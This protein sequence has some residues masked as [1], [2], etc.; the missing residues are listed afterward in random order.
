MVFIESTLKTT[1]IS[2]A[3]LRI[4]QP[5][6]SISIRFLWMSP[7][8]CAYSAPGNF[9]SR[10]LHSLKCEQHSHWDSTHKGGADM[11]E[12]I[13]IFAIHLHLRQQDFLFV[14][15]TKRKKKSPSEN[16]LR[17]KYHKQD[18]KISHSWLNLKS[19]LSFTFFF[20]F[21]SNRMILPKWKAWE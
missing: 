16:P 15:Q 2:R 19:L 4:T 18:K 13:Y 14:V 8:K 6:I 9:P 12:Y 7:R 5:I 3:T 10:F 20:H 11:S 21:M 1:L 17:H